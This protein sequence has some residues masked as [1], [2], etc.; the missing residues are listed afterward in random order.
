MHTCFV[1][2][3]DVVFLSFR[4]RAED[5]VKHAI[6]RKE[7]GEKVTYFRLQ[8]NITLEIFAFIFRVKMPIHT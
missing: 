3:T 2:Q 8:R 6:I 1:L 7:N 4:G 5:G